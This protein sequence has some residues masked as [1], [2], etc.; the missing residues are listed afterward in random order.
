MTKEE[1]KKTYSEYTVYLYKENDVVL[2][3]NTSNF[4]VARKNT[5]RNTSRTVARRTTY[6]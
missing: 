2:R 6:V 5:R 1:L 4:Y 3:A